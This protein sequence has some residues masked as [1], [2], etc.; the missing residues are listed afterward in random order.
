[1]CCDAQVMAACLRGEEWEKSLSL[2]RELCLGPWEFHARSVLFHVSR[3][4]PSSL[5][6]GK[7][8][9]WSVYRS[10]FEAY[11][12]IICRGF[13]Q[14]PPGLA[15][16]SRFVLEICASRTAPIFL[17]FQAQKWEAALQT[18]LEVPGAEDELKIVTL[19]L[20]SAFAMFDP[21]NHNRMISPHWRQRPAADLHV[22]GAT[23]RACSVKWQQ[24]RG[25][26]AGKEWKEWSECQKKQTQLSGPSFLEWA[27]WESWLHLHPIEP[28][29][30]RF[31]PA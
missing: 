3:T 23:L 17:V 29:L 28:W 20:G 22:L 11:S 6:T 26:L 9:V 10:E 24:V 18:F 8:D 1:M 5:G 19:N 4:Q 31:K 16:L 25:N 13:G 12:I 7:L 30:Q 15:W 14:L 2:F 27:P 21:D